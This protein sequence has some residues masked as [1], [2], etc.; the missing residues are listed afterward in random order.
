MATKKLFNAKSQQV[1]DAE[2]TVNDNH[3]ILATFAD[4]GFVKFPP[5]LTQDEFDAL[6]EAHQ[7]AN[8]G[9]EPVTE[10]SI[11]AEAALHNNSL[12][13]IGEKPEATKKIEVTEDTT[14]EDAQ[15]NATDTSTDSPI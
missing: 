7:S 12:A 2:F 11:A 5:G 15:S 6:L 10:E 9:Q 14:S 8:E 3:E 13:L 4:G 1:E